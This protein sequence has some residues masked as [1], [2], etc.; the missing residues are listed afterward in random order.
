MSEELIDIND[1]MQPLPVSN[2]EEG[3][4]LHWK[5]GVYTKV[6]HPGILTEYW[7]GDQIEIPASELVTPVNPRRGFR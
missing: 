7:T 2:V 3:A 6:R 4:G 5:G 1:E